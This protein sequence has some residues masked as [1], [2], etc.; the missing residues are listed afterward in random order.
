[1]PDETS[2]LQMLMEVYDKLVKC[3]E[4]LPVA[5]NEVRDCCTP[6]KLLHL[7]GHEALGCSNL[8][9]VQSADCTACCVWC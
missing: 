4:L 3:D 5:A 7:M 8:R 6:S 9:M 1:M 2:A